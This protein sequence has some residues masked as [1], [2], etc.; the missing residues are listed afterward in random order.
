MYVCLRTESA[1][2][3]RH[4]R[5]TL[6]RLPKPRLAV[7]LR[8]ARGVTYTGSTGLPV[9]RTGRKDRKLGRTPL[10]LRLWRAGRLQRAAKHTTQTPDPQW[11]RCPF[12]TPPGRSHSY[13][14]SLG[15]NPSE[16]CGSSNQRR[17]R[18][19]GHVY[20]GRR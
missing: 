4:S 15:R 3:F 19:G 5:G 7:P 16:R 6:Q 17:A 18:I 2:H 1:K 10:P 13:K 20:R 9:S 8:G 11:R 12:I 14:S